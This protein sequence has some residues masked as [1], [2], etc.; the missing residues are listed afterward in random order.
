MH[1]D[2]APYSIERIAAPLRQQVLEELRRAI[3]DGELAPGTRLIERDLCERLKVSRTV[4]RESLRQLE[5]EGLVGMIAN[6]GPVVRSLG[7]AEAREL[8]AIRAVLE[9]LAARIFAEQA[10]AAQIERL[11]NSVADI[12][13]AYR[14]QNPKMVIGAK[15]RF[16]AVLFEAAHGEVLGAMLATLNARI[17]RWRVLGLTHP[18]RSPERSAQSVAAL[19]ALVAAIAAR[20]PVSAE[21]L[22]RDAAANA[23]AEVFRLLAERKDLVAGHGDTQQKSRSVL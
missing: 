21:Q 5:S 8:Y 4:I 9:G 6:R 20:D 3:I 22:A 14:A 13:S 2:K 7:M 23:A 16:Y 18:G 15:G 11:K 10:T 1:M 17:S 19:R 12:E